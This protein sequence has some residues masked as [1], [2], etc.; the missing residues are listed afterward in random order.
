MY[1]CSLHDVCGE[2][3]VEWLA[4][5][6]LVRLP[7]LLND[8]GFRSRN[9]G[10]CGS[11]V[12]QDTRLSAVGHA[13]TSR[14]HNLMFNPGDGV[15]HLWRRRLE[16]QHAGTAAGSILPRT[17]WPSG[18]RE[19][20]S[21]AGR[22][23]GCEL[24]V[25]NDARQS[26]GATRRGFPVVAPA[27]TWPGLAPTVRPPQG[28]CW[29]C[30]DEEQVQ[31]QVQK[32]QAQWQQQQATIGYSAGARAGEKIRNLRELKFTVKSLQVSTVKSGVALTRQDGVGQFYTHK[33]KL[34]VDH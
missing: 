23:A 15:P 21:G 1:T 28:S 6:H 18:D 27:S 32:V 31:E 13:H 24:A 3:H 33:L 7:H 11:S 25:R 5:K 30:L 22:G 2:R 12:R 4:G 34:T 9:S 14:P 17:P 8:N 20:A 16:R 10:N 29:D 26:T 19:P